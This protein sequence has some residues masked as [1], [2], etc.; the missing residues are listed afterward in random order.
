MNYIGTS[1]YTS[2]IDD[3]EVVEDSE[4]EREQQRRTWRRGNHHP[5][6]DST[7]VIELTDSSDTDSPSVLPKTGSFPILAS[8]RTTVA[9]TQHPNPTQSSVEAGNSTNHILGRSDSLNFQ[10]FAFQDSGPSK[11]KAPRR[12]TPST[13]PS[14]RKA[15]S[16]LP[17]KELDIPVNDLDNVISCV[18]CDVKWTT[19]K[20]SAQKLTH[21]RTCAKL[22]GLEISTIK[23]LIQKQTGATSKTTGKRAQLDHRGSPE[24]STTLFENVVPGVQ[25]HKRNHQKAV[26][27]LLSSPTSGR[28]AILSRA[29]EVLQNSDTLS[30]NLTQAAPHK[31]ERRPDN[32]DDDPANSDAL[33]FGQSLLGQQLSSGSGII[34]MSYE[35]VSASLATSE[36]PH[37]CPSE[38]ELIDHFTA[39]KVDTN[40]VSIVAEKVLTGDCNVPQAQLATPKLKKSTK[41]PAFDDAW[42]SHMDTSIQADQVLYLRILRYE[43]RG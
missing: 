12:A 4:P 18:S 8:V 17:K 23:I 16:P 20:T 33:E 28:D 14:L 40:K 7:S 1:R 32:Q 39:L 25:T 13:K 21:I 22:H 9:E 31:I 27:T 38:E 43:V 35:M 11:F 37:A 6:E 29:Q 24:S 2:S 42:R 30:Y 10:Q 5:K 3:M 36:Q 15:S 34:S 26:R 41:T 19:R